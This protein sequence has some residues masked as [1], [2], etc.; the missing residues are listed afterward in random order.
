MFSLHERDW[1]HIPT[2][3][4]NHLS[5]VAQQ[6]GYTSL[7]A[8]WGLIQEGVELRDDGGRRGMWRITQ[9]GEDWIKGKITIPK[10]VRVYN[11]KC[12]GFTGEEITV[13][14]ALGEGFNLK[15]LMAGH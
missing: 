7:T 15:T 3:V 8:Y 10:Y 2:L 11:G 6:G 4:A 13:Q 12:V 14:Q 1:V 5:D 9:K